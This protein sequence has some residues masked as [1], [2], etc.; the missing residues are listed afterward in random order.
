MNGKYWYGDIQIGIFIIHMLLR[1]VL[2]YQVRITQKLQFAFSGN[3][4][5]KLLLTVKILKQSLKPRDF[6]TKPQ[7]Y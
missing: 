2:K 4:N 6:H 3:V 1:T 5:K 7:E